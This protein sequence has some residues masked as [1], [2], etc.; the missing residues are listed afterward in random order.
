MDLGKKS[1]TGSFFFYVFKGAQSLYRG[2]EA[3]KILANTWSGLARP[4]LR[5]RLAN[6]AQQGLTS[7]ARITCRPLCLQTRTH[8]YSIVFI[9]LD[10]F[11][12]SNSDFTALRAK[13][14][15]L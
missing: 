13:V 1:L 14:F 11:N 3:I 12:L 2:T 15:T 7:T 9:T 5:R 8:I 4:R 6:P 10:F